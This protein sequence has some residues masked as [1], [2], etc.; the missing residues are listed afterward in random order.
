MSF[1]NSSSKRSV[2][3]RQKPLRATSD[4]TTIME[5]HQNLISH[6]LSTPFHLLLTFQQQ[7][8]PAGVFQFAPLPQQWLL[9]QE[10]ASVYPYRRSRAH[11]RKSHFLFQMPQ[12][13]TL[14]QKPLSLSDAA[15]EHASSEAPF[16]FRC[17]SR[18]C[19]RRSRI[20]FRMPQQSTRPQKPHSISDAAAESAS[21]E[22]T[23]SFRCRSRARVLRSPILFQMPQ[24]SLLP[25]K[26]LSL[27]DAA[28]ESASAEATFSFRCR[29]RARVLRS[30]IL[31]QM[32]QQ[33]L[34]PQK[35]HSLSDAAAEHASSEAHSISDA[36]ELPA[37]GEP[38]PVFPYCHSS[39]RSL[40]E[41]LSLSFSSEGFHRSQLLFPDTTTTKHTPMTSSTPLTL[42]LAFLGGHKRSYLDAVLFKFFWGGV[43]LRPGQTQ[44][45]DPSPRTV[46]EPRARESC[47]ARSPLPG[48]H[49]KYA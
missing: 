24:Q 39:S 18:V 32:P 21:A 33:S 45:S 42:S 5:A 11:F 7:L 2:A 34:L 15:T 48:Q 44:S 25:Q 41:P 35:P 23:F 10:I 29:S 3:G 19:F 22:A 28:A 40:K 17:R 37:S 26:P 49:A 13:S 31:F 27:S 6:P 8:A 30:P 47:R 12:Q 14:L 36:A 1:P 4:R 20:L 9:P 38:F 16:Y 43:T 46:G